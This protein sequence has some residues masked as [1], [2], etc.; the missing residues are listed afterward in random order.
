MGRI[1]QTTKTKKATVIIIL[2]FTF[3]FSIFLPNSI[4][5]P[6]QIS[7]HKSGYE[8]YPNKPS[9]NDCTSLPISNKTSP[10]KIRQTRSKKDVIISVTP[11]NS[12]V[13]NLF[14]LFFA[15]TP[16]D[17]IILLKNRTRHYLLVTH[18]ILTQFIKICNIFNKIA[19]SN[20]R[21]LSIYAFLQ[22]I[23]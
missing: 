5:K 7:T 15:F 19:K 18:S 21:F 22:F 9:N 20:L 3:C 8:T 4:A 23:K 12:T 13:K 1:K 16:L 10:P 17:K 6:T 11:K 2:L 14:S